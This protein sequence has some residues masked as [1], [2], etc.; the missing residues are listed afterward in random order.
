MA[1]ADSLQAQFNKY[2]SKTDATKKKAATLSEVT[3]WMKANKVF[4]TNFSSNHLDIC[5]AK[6][7][8]KKDGK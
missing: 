5:W 8:S 3:K 2:A 6:H 7:A 4:K 1:A